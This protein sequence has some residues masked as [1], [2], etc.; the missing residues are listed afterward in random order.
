MPFLM[1]LGLGLLVHAPLEYV[2]PL[3][4]S[5]GLTVAFLRLVLPGSFSA[6]VGHNPQTHGDLVDLIACGVVQAT[7]LR[8]TSTDSLWIPLSHSMWSCPM[9]LL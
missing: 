8:Q 7:L 5:A 4:S 9:V 1:N 3:L 6:E 2:I